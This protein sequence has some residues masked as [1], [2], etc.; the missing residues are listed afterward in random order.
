[1]RMGEPSKVWVKGDPSQLRTGVI[2]RWRI[3]GIT[4]G[5]GDWRSFR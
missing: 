5:W 4:H 3:E 1:M 2:F